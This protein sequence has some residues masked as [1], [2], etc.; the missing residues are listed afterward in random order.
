MTHTPGPWGPGS[1]VQ[2]DGSLAVMGPGYE[3]VARVDEYQTP[4]GAA[5]L[6]LIAAAPDLLDAARQAKA[7][8]ESLMDELVGKKAT[9]WGVVNNAMVSLGR[10]I[11]KAEG[12]EQ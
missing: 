3:R 10:A 4:V 2:N 7:A 9:D 5:N 12:Q 6:S 8:G 11:R 1:T